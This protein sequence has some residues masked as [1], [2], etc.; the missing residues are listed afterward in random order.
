MEIEGPT[1]E[2][3]SCRFL[4]SLSGVWSIEDGRLVWRGSEDLTPHRGPSLGTCSEGRD[5][6]ID[7]DHPV[8][9]VLE[10]EPVSDEDYASLLRI[11]QQS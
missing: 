3:G 8:G 1:I 5:C 2:C 10:G 11:S 6:N 9:L 7:R 4:A